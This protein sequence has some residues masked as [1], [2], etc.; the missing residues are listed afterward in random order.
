M[1]DDRMRRRF[2][3]LVQVVSLTVLL[4]AAPVAQAKGHRY[5]VNNTT[6]RAECGSCHVAYPPALLGADAW[7]A[8]MLGL[9]RHFGTDASLA[10]PARAEIGGFLAAQAAARG[11]AASTRISETRWFRKEHADIA[12][13]TWKAPAVGSPAN[14][15]ACHRNADRGDYG[16][17]SIRLPH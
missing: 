13:A 16:E 2:G 11:R 6:Y 9:D 14:C 1:I 5:P 8:I 10:E 4:M 7:R 12:A 15:D 3:A 17:C